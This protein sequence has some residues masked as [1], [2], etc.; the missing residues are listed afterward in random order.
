[1]TICLWQTIDVSLLLTFKIIIKTWIFMECLTELHCFTIYV[2]LCFYT[3]FADLFLSFDDMW[4]RISNTRKIQWK[5]CSAWT[6]WLQM[7]W[8]ML[9][10][11]FSIWLL[12]R[13][14]PFSD[15]VPSLRYGRRMSLLF[16]EDAACCVTCSAEMYICA[17][18][19]YNEIILWQ[20]LYVAIFFLHL[21]LF[22]VLGWQNC[23]QR[24]VGPLCIMLTA[25]A[26]NFY[27]IMDLL[28][29][30]K[31]YILKGLKEK[32]ILAHLLKA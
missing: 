7:L 25:L 30:Y 28:S 4:F 22:L 13:T 16:K 10:I 23:R 21:F 27:M 9:K 32:V 31:L 3:L 17:P 26:S 29:V 11:V 20:V 18:R 14:L 6:T 2:T 5:L 19:Q 8:F 15:F 12:W 24:I 1:M